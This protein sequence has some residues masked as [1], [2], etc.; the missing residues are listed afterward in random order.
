MET[1]GNS[2]SART[3]TSGYG[4]ISRFMGGAMGKFFI[5]IALV[6]IVGMG[7][8]AS[9]ASAQ[10][11]SRIRAA[12]V[13]L[14]V[15]D[16]L[17]R[18]DPC[19]PQLIAE[20]VREISAAE[21]EL[22]TIAPAIRLSSV[23]GT[24]LADGFVDAQEELKWSVD[25]ALAACKP[26]QSLFGGPPVP[27]AAQ[28]W[29][30][31]FFGGGGGHTEFNDFNV[32]TSGIAGG[33]FLEFDVARAGQATFS[34]RPGFLVT[35]IRGENRVEDVKTRLDW[36]GTLDFKA[37]WLLLSDTRLLY[38][39]VPGD[40]RPNIP[41]TADNTSRAVSELAMA[42]FAGPAFGRTT[43]TTFS[44]EEK[45]TQFGWSAGLG[46]YTTFNLPGISNPLQI[47]LEGRYYDLG[48]TSFQGGRDV[49]QNGAIGT[50]QVKIPIGPLPFAPVIM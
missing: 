2:D 24:S 15:L 27:F 13:H 12:T 25:L 34:I 43:V 8:F 6:S 10:D 38:S 29:F 31:L 36:I 11:F 35:N 46:I 50:I 3:L 32:D 19:N 47:G 5:R 48:K 14:T 39:T 18:T 17:V 1:G 49:R 30:G 21:R 28:V 4:N 22:D 26:T 33:A 9:A 23:R 41:L 42:V 20:A 40:V 45:K 37:T 7:A 44:E 16:N